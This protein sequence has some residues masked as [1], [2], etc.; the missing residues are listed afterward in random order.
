MRQVAGGCKRIAS[1]VFT[2]DIHNSK[3]EITA[4]GSPQNPPPHFCNG[5]VAKLYQTGGG[6]LENPMIRHARQRGSYAQV[7]S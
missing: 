7:I 3:N 4:I 1:Q 2:G 6:L 5:C